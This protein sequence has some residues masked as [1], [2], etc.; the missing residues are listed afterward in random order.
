MN[1]LFTHQMIP[2]TTT[3]L[4]QRRSIN[5]GP[6]EPYT[7]TNVLPFYLIQYVV[8]VVI[9]RKWTKTLSNS[10]EKSMVAW[11]TRSFTEKT[12]LKKSL[13]G[14]TVGC[15][16]EESRVSKRSGVEDDFEGF[17]TVMNIH[18]CHWHIYERLKKEH[19]R[20]KKRVWF[21]T[22]RRFIL[23]IRKVNLKF[24]GRIKAKIHRWEALAQ[25]S[26]LN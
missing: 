8:F 1:I 18:N 4:C 13:D 20:E 25:M 15:K 16:T 5:L 12:G 23:D 22:S 9:N 11:S 6:P 10:G 7:K 26:N 17:Q 2:W 3:Q 19:R 14:S 21:S 24:G